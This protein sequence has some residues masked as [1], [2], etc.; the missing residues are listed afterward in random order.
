MYPPRRTSRTLPSQFSFGSSIQPPDKSGALLINIPFMTC[1]QPPDN[2]HF[3][4]SLLTICAPRLQ[5][6]LV[7]KLTQ[8]IDSGSATVINKLHIWLHEIVH[9]SLATQVHIDKVSILNISWHDAGSLSEYGDT[10]VAL[11]QPVSQWRYQDQWGY[12]PSDTALLFP[13]IVESESCGQMLEHGA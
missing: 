2:L 9:V 10:H 7:H 1:L 5:L 11:T 4:P 8:P 6:E 3:P 13:S 12:Q